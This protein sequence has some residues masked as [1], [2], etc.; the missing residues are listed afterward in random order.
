[1]QL[2]R[3]PFQPIL[4]PELLLVP[5]LLLGFRSFLECFV[6]S[7]DVRWALDS[8]AFHQFFHRAELK[9]RILLLNALVLVAAGTRGFGHHIACRSEEH[10]SELQSPMYLVCRLL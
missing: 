1:M 4:Q 3:Y 5:L 9:T 8:V 7:G 10:T 6:Q 2:G